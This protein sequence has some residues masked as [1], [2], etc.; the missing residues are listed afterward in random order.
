MRWQRRASKTSEWYSLA[1]LKILVSEGTISP[2]LGW[3]GSG[4]WDR[5]GPCFTDLLVGRR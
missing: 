5:R 3:I 2:L 4:R 1:L